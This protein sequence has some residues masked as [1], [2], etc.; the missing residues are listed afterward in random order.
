MTWITFVRTFPKSIRKGAF[1]STTLYS[2]FGRGGSFK[3]VKYELTHSEAWNINCNQ[4]KYLPVSA[5]WQQTFLRIM[6]CESQSGGKWGTLSPTY[7]VKKE[8]SCAPHRH[9]VG[10]ISGG[11]KKN[12]FFLAY[13]SP[14]KYIAHLRGETLILCPA[15]NRVWG[16][17]H[18]FDATFENSRWIK[19]WWKKFC[20]EFWSRFW[21]EFEQQQQQQGRHCGSQLD[22]FCPELKLRPLTG[23][24]HHPDQVALNFFLSL[25]GLTALY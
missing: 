6:I 21:S 10:L 12:P 19:T 7:A 1:L 8:T 15:K 20:N 5:L 18:G 2:A 11:N 24:H 14:P 9:A 23:H 16:K 25:L 13:S 4:C 22:G 17:A 3:S